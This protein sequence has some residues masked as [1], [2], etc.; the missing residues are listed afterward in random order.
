MC[1]RP[2]VRPS[3]R[4]S[5][6]RFRPTQRRVP[7]RRQY[8]AE[9]SRARACAT[10]DILRLR[11]CL[12]DG[13]LI[14]VIFMSLLLIK[15]SIR[16]QITQK[17]NFVFVLPQHPCRDKLCGG[18]GRIQKNY[19]VI[20]LECPVAKCGGAAAQGSVAPFHLDHFK[21]T[22]FAP[23][24]RTSDGRTDIIL[25]QGSIPFPFPSP[26]SIL[27]MPSSS[28]FSFKPRVG[29]SSV[30]TRKWLSLSEIKLLNIK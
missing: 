7:R 21:P 10:E 6:L 20:L 11:N 5:S 2:S 26:L 8:R 30:S 12:R 28:H 18:G 17:T 3:V 29:S 19:R 27:H 9:L 24:R 15:A 23:A 22:Q 4:P 16:G 13:D 25:R 14:A 1:P